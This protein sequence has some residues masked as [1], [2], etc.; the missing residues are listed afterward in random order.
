MMKVK[1]KKAASFTFSFLDNEYGATS[2]DSAFSADMDLAIPDPALINFLIAVFMSAL[3]CTSK[4]ASE[5]IRD[6]QKGLRDIQR[7]DEGLSNFRGHTV[8]ASPFILMTGG[9]YAL[10]LLVNRWD[11]EQQ[12]NQVEENLRTARNLRSLLTDSSTEAM[13]FRINEENNAKT[14]N[15]RLA[16][17]ATT[18]SLTG[19]YLGFSALQVTEF[20]FSFIP[21]IVINPLPFVVTGIILGAAFCAKRLYEQYRLDL[22]KSISVLACKIELGQLSCKQLQH[23]IALNK[24]SPLAEKLHQQLITQKQAVENQHQQLTSMQEKLNSATQWGNNFLNVSQRTVSTIKNTSVGLLNLASFASFT[25]VTTV[26][27]LAG[28]TVLSI[29][30]GPAGV[31]LM[32]AVVVCAVIYAG[33]EM[34]KRHQEQQNQKLPAKTEIEIKNRHSYFFKNPSVNDYAAKPLVSAATCHAR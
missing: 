2:Y 24:G 26:K 17:Q 23:D 34:H 12:L 20:V 33:Y 25:G 13:T 4:E 7:V 22:K 6:V 3:K 32:A 27:I 19:L 21:S 28:A 29:L 16:V 14:N 10:L 5:N 11:R 18:G 9:F 8:I 30:G 31:A 15:L 1:I